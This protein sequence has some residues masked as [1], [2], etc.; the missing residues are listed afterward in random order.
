LRA[1]EPSYFDPNDSGSLDSSP[2]SID[3]VAATGSFTSASPLEE[4]AVQHE[5]SAQGVP[6]EHSKQCHPQ[7]RPS[8]KRK[9]VD[10][11]ATA[12]N[13]ETL[14]YGAIKALFSRASHMIR[15][16]SDLEGIIFV[17]AS[18]Q[19]IEIGRVILD[20]DTYTT[21]TET[22][23]Q[24]NARSSLGR[25]NSTETRIEKPS[26]DSRSFKLSINKTSS[27]SQPSTTCE[28]L[29]YSLRDAPCGSNVQPSTPQLTISQTVLRGLL[30]SYPYGQI[31]MFDRSGLPIHHSDID[32]RRKSKGRLGRRRS[33][34]D[35][36][37]EREKEQLR[38]YQ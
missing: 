36:K 17:N 32:P 5:R 12:H 24:S 2:D 8:P 22:E 33:N 9:C 26:S 37:L 1:P 19:D 23:T 18:L 10:E 16:A 27:I 29:G 4:E 35:T 13:E 21:Q 3:S 25:S 14:S 6:P 15:E 7:C 20:A 30:K 38:S 34:K 31:F 11:S 28:M